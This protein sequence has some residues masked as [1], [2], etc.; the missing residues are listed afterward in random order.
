MMSRARQRASM[1]FGR[2]TV[3]GRNDDRREAAERRQAAEPPLLRF[4]AIELLGVAGNERRDDGMLRLPGLQQG[5][6]QFVAAPGAPGR[7]TQKLKRALGRARVGV[8]EADV[9]VDDTDKSQK[10]EVVP[11]GDQLRADDEVVG[12]A[13][14]RLELATGEVSIPP[15]VSDDNTSVR[16][17]GKRAS[18][19]SARRS[20][21]GPQAVS[22]SASWH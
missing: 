11:F 15:G 21:P 9:G 17:S 2:A 8:G 10:R 20:T 22:V 6:S 3:L 16:M 13:R 4:L 18:A 14:R 7:L 12:A 19:S 5:M 1:R